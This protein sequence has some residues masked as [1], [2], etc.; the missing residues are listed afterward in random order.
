MIRA[1]R[2]P[3]PAAGFTLIELLITL[4]LLS[5]LMTFGMPKLLN[6]IQRQ[7]ILGFTQQTAILLRLARLEAIKTSTNSIVTTNQAGTVVQAFSDPNGNNTLDAGEDEL[8]RLDLP[9]G[10]SLLAISGFTPQI[11]PKPS[12]A[13]YRPNGSILAPG[14]FQFQDP[15][16]D[17]LEARVMSKSG[18]QVLIQK[19]LGGSWHAQDEGGKPWTWK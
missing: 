5:I 10:V 16:G 1:K 8:G 2:P 3:G 18:G 12:V 13:V 11:S 19:E 9:K 14:A 15:N 6:M 17:Q 4:A 7:K